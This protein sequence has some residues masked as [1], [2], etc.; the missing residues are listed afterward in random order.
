MYMRSRCPAH[1]AVR[2]LLAE[3]QATQHAVQLRDVAQPTLRFAKPAQ[4]S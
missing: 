2:F 4:V 1:L 3:L